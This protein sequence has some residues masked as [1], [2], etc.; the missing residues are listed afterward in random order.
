MNA[1]ISRVQVRRTGA[2]SIQLNFHPRATMPQRLEAR[3]LELGI[4]AEQL[5]HRFISVGM[6]DHV[7]SFTPAALGKSLDDFL[8]RNGALTAA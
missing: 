4:T 5:I 2:P 8:V 7:D 1:T 3:A 6:R